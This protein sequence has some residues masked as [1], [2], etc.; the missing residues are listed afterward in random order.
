MN[1]RRA[2][3]LVRVMCLT[4]LVVG[5]RNGTAQDAPDSASVSQVT[6]VDGVVLVGAVLSD[7]DPLRLRLLSGDVIE[8][9][10]AR[11]RSVGPVEGR[12]VGGSLWPDDPNRTSLFLGPTARTLPKGRGYVG[13]Y[14]LFFPLVGV[15]VT[16]HITLAGGM[17][18]LSSFIEDEI[19]YV[20]PKVRLP[21]TG[22]GL[23]VAVGGLAFVKAGRG[24]AGVVYGV[25]TV[26]TRDRSVTFGGL[27]PWVDESWG[28]TP[29]A[30]VGF[31]VRTSK[32]IKLISENYVSTDGSLLVFGPR[33]LGDRISADLGVALGISDG[34]AG[35]FPL[36]NFMYTW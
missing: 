10:Q 31:E 36:I 25:A 29:F 2:S 23:D 19:F 3:L 18:I 26:G 16:D 1:R 17:P 27:W 24:S 5:A 33:F 22:K 30:L 4:V 8:I 9:A 13:T 21:S 11:V 7:G 35:L 34:S 15:G 20:A 12:V 32:S 28:R 6:L 14:E